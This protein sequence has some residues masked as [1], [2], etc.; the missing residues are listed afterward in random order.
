MTAI[1]EY[2]KNAS[3]GEFC[4]GVFLGVVFIKMIIEILKD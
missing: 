3:I 1:V 4:L 2:F